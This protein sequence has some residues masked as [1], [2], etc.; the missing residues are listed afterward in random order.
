[1]S[2]IEISWPKQTLL[3]EPILPHPQFILAHPFSI[4]IQN[5]IENAHCKPSLPKLQTPH[6]F[7][8][9]AQPCLPS[10]PYLNV[11]GLD[12]S[13]PSLPSTSDFYFQFDGA[14]RGTFKQQVPPIVFFL[15]HVFILSSHKQGTFSLPFYI[16]ISFYFGFQCIIER[17]VGI[18]MSK[19]AREITNRSPLVQSLSV[20][21]FYFLFLVRV[22]LDFQVRAYMKL[23]DW[24]QPNKCDTIRRVR[25]EQKL[26]IILSV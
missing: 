8:L 9:F 10:T 18:R 6:I 19:G 13:V 20:K 15:F 26:C 5:S 25:T 2:L 17:R 11:Q 1:M 12:D 23:F 14:A 4:N 16:S 3:R 22:C 24:I 7:F 21:V